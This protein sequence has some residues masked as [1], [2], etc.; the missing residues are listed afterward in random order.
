MN[1][2]VLEV[3]FEEVLLF[4]LELVLILDLIVLGRLLDVLMVPVRLVDDLVVF[5]LVLVGDKDLDLVF[6]DK[7][8]AI[9]DE[10]VE[11]GSS[12]VDITGSPGSVEMNTDSLLIDSSVVD[13][14]SGDVSDDDSSDV[15]KE[16][17]LVSVVSNSEV[18]VDSAISVDDGISLDELSGSLEVVDVS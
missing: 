1:L 18:V 7:E 15:S 12:E 8:D 11:E 3:F 5:V 17:E 13:D 10:G 14:D 16:D 4:G 9:M 6:D 2:L